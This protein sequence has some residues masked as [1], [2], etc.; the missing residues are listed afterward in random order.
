VNQT[1]ETPGAAGATMNARLRVGFDNPFE[2]FAW[3]ENGEPKGML[4][5]LV[6]RVLEESGLSWTFAPLPL[7][8]IEQAL[9]EGRIDAIAFKGVTPERERS[10]SFSEPLLVTGGAI[11]TR[12]GRPPSAN[13]RDYAGRTVVTPRRGP[14]YAPIAR[15]YPELAL[16]DGESY[17][18]SFDALLAGRA[19]LA[20]L[21]WQAGIRMANR[22]YPGRV[23]LPEAPYVSVPL[24]FAVGK[25]RM[26]GAMQRF[27]DAQAKLAGSLE[28]IAAK[29]LE[30]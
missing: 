8:E 1:R 21:N 7:E 14:L 3:V 24:A 15:Q 28:R 18:G 11:F 12:K 13:L 17:E 22:R 29:W 9:S 26:G 10:L 30:E 20:A 23:E 5:E 25:G 27:R 19:D 6:A 2:P 16:L 4:I